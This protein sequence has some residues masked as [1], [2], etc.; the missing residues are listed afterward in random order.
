MAD[1]ICLGRCGQTMH[2]ECALH[3]GA[4]LHPTPRESQR[5]VHSHIWSPSLP[6]Q[7][8]YRVNLSS[9]SSTYGVTYYTSTIV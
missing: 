9:F 2:A 8:V 7:N 3:E 6:V 4:F 1:K 5:C